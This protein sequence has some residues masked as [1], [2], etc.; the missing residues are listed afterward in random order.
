MSRRSV[1][2]LLLLACG[3]PHSP[4]PHEEASPT[5]SSSPNASSTSAQI[6][7]VLAALRAQDGGAS[8]SQVANVE[9]AVSAQLGHGLAPDAVRQVVL[10]HQQSLK[11]CYDAELARDPDLKG[12][13]T[14]TWLIAPDGTVSTASVAASTIRNTNVESCVLRVVRSWTF[15]T[16]DGPTNVAAYPFKFGTLNK[17]A[18]TP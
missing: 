5:P 2:F 14:M 8:P 18:S 15:P 11:Q 10:R 12:G 6:A 17:P 1:S 13:I 7:S 3:G 4:A 16:S 9:A